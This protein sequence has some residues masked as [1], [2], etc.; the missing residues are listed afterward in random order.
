MKQQCTQ[1]YL[2][3]HTRQINGLNRKHRKKKYIYMYSMK[4]SVY[5]E[6]IKYYKP[7]AKGL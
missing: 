4:N 6:L 3:V 2:S 7:F 1:E 5:V